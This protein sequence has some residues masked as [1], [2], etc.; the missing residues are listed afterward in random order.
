MTSP[1]PHPENNLKSP[2]SVARAARGDPMPGR[3][4]LALILLAIAIGLAE[5]WIDM[6]IRTDDALP[7]VILVGAPCLLFALI[8]PRHAWRWGLLIGG[9]IPLC[10][11][12]GAALGY[13]AAYPAQPNLFASFIALLPAM[14][15]SY[16]GAGI[17]AWTGAG[18]R[19]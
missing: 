6:R 12:A 5:G 11:F 17:R 19:A 2:D 3:S 7:S 10:H 14:A 16:L 9:G 18:R 13:R 15:A 4:T 1:S 8:W